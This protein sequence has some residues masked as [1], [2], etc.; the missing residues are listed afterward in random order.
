MESQPDVSCYQDELNVWS[1]PCFTYI[2]YATVASLQYM[3]T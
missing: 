1:I 2:I 3:Y